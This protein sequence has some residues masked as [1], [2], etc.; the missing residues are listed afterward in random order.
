[1][2][3]RAVVKAILGATLSIMVLLPVTDPSLAEKPRSAPELVQRI[4]AATPGPTNAAEMEA[5]FD[6]IMAKHMA[7]YHIPGATISVVKDGELF[8]AKGYGYANL[9]KSVPFQPETSLVRI[10]SITK[11]F[12]WTAV[13]QLVEQGKLDLNAD[14]NTYLSTFQVPNTYPEPI[15]LAHLMSHTAGFEDRSIG[16]GARKKQDVPSLGDYLAQH[17]PAR[18]RP[19][20]Q[21]SAYSN[22]GAA[23]AGYIV[24]EVS[25]MPYEQYIQ[26]NILAPLDMGHTTASE[27]VPDHLQADLA[28]SYEYVNGVYKPIPFL[29]DILVPDGSISASATDMAHFM[30]A[31]LQDGRYADSRILQTGTAQLMHSQSFTHH[32][33]MSGRAHGFTELEINDQHALSHDGSWEGFESLLVLLPQ[34]NLG[35]FVSYNSLGGLDAMDE[36]L[37]AFFDHYFPTS[38]SSMSQPPAHLDQPVQQF[39]GWYKLARS[40]ETTIEKLVTLISSSRMVALDAD[41]L[42][43]DGRTWVAVEPLLYREVDGEDL[44]AFL[45]NERGQIIYAAIGTRAYEKIPWYETILVNLALLG[46]CIALFLSALIGWPI[47]LVVQRR[48]KGRQNAMPGAPCVARWVAALGS[49]LS[50]AFIVVV[51]I[52]LMGDTFE[53]IYG[54][55]LGFRVLMLVPFVVAALTAAATVLAVLAWRDRYWS[56][57]GRLHYTLV[58][59]ALIGC[60]W[61]MNTWNLLGFRFG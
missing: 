14:V 3:S 51:A 41:T 37:Q 1:M 11:L 43:F 30:I 42:R 35:L 15:T 32:P 36:M 49:G 24:A 39:A 17:L 23:L 18:V 50:V 48:K 47:L 8:F 54:V 61:F 26:E 53:F 44:M 27:P 60:L 25:G 57:W 45:P 33:Q 55:P 40:S 56:L 29:Y 19:P 38:N 52:A 34:Y 9:D 28:A 4:H 6:E 20:G 16:T 10:A 59:L 22:H 21:I 7:S 2:M 13:M 5:F 31:H 12:T 46:S 58:A